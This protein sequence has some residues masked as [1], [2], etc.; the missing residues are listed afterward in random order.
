MLVNCRNCKRQIETPAMLRRKSQTFL[1]LRHQ[2][3]HH[4]H[5]YHRHCRHNRH[6]HRYHNQRSGHSQLYGLSYDDLRLYDNL[7]LLARYL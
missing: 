5:T 1:Y 7:S 6:R 2:R 3:S 4:N